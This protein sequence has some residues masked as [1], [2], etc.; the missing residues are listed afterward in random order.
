MAKDYKEKWFTY[1]ARLKKAECKRKVLPYDISPEYLESIWTLHCPVFG[2]EFVRFDKT[3]DNSP[4][5]DRMIP[6]LGYV[7]GN[8]CYISARANRIK[9]DATPEEIRKVLAFMEGATT[10]ESTSE[11]E[12]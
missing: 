1:Q 7:R 8:L 10:I 5:L 2:G 12:S 9:Y 6:E 11:D 4:A 3:N